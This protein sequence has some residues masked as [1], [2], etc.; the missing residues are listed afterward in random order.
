MKELE[1]DKQAPSD[2]GVLVDAGSPAET[3]KKKKGKK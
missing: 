3:G 2:D 1:E